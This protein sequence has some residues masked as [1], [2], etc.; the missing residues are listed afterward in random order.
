MAELMIKKVF[1][2]ICM[3]IEGH[4]AEIYHFYSRIFEDNPE[5]SHIWNKAAQE[6]ESHRKQFEMA[7]LLMR[8][9]EFEVPMDTLKR[10]YSVK[11]RLM[12]HIDHIK[13]NKPDLLTAVSKA[14]EMEDKL[15]DLH[16]YTALKF[17]DDSMRKLFKEMSDSDRDH[18]AVLQRYHSILCMMNREMGK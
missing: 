12:T 3:D 1:L 11:V 6:E 8:E 10:A 14:V 9:N 17:N 16:V 5:A 18:V 2:D 15:A 4:C 7:L 13:S